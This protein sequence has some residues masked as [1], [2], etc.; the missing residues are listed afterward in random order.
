[1]NLKW[2]NIFDKFVTFPEL[3]NEFP[4]ILLS[5][6]TGTGK[7]KAVNYLLKKIGYKK[8]LL[9][10]NLISEM[11]GESVININNFFTDLKH[12]NEKKIAVVIDEIDSFIARRSL[13]N[14]NN[15]AGKEMDRITNSILMNMDN[16]NENVLFFAMTN[17]PE[18]LD[19]AFIRRFDIHIKFETKFEIQYLKKYFSK[20]IKKYGV[21]PSKIEWKNKN[22][23]EIKNAIKIIYLENYQKKKI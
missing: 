14:N 7:T 17:F 23:Y 9:D 10:S 18:S 4:K 6:K 3:L 13:K 16:L 5:G 20:D 19:N 8:I 1:M 2:N 11:L 15:S 21:D 22:P 12:K